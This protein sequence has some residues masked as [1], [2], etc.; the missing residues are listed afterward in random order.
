MQAQ[1]GLA[2]L[3]DRMHLRPEVVG[4]QEIVGNPQASRGIAF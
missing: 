3:L 1:L 4:A 2:R